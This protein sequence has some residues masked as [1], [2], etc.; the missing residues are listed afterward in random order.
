MEEL[1]PGSGDRTSPAL[2]L[3]EQEA[4]WVEVKK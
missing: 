3:D 2:T 1:L 4:L